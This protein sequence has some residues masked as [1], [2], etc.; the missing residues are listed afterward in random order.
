MIKMMS[1]ALLAVS[2]LAA[3][4]LAAGPVRS[5]AARDANAKM[6]APH[7]R[8]HAHPKMHRSHVRIVRPHHKLVRHHRVHGRLGAHTS[9][10]VAKVT[11]KHIGHRG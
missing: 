10:H 1:A 4:A 2:L 8:V 7:V 3:P 11:V 9:H 5:D 6:H